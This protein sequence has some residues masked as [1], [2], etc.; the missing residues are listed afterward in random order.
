MGISYDRVPQTSRLFLDYAY[1][2]PR[3]AEFFSAPPAELSG[4]RDL[5]RRLR[6]PASARAGLCD[7]LKR[8]NQTF[9]APAAVFSNLERLQDE[10][11]YAVVTGQQVGLFSGP[12][13][14]IYKALTAVKAAQWLS[15]NGLP[16]VPVFWLATEDH[17]L[18]EVSQ[19]A[20]LDAEYELVPISASPNRPAPHSS[21]GSVTVPESIAETFLALEAAL[22]DGAGRETVLRDL[23]ESYRP[24]V[25]LS[26]AFARLMARLFGRWGVIL[27]DSLD[28]D[29]R[30]LSAPV[31]CKALDE[32]GTLRA[33]LLERSAALEAAGYHAQVRVADDSTLLFQVKDG[34]RRALRE[35]D[36]K[37]QSEEN[38][39]LTARELRTEFEQDPLSLSG[40]VLM[41]PIIQDT[42]LPT[43]AYVAGPSELAYLGQAQAIYASFGRPMPVVIPRA[44]FTLV[45]ARIQRVLDKYQLTLE[46]VWQ[47]EGA[48]TLKIAA[49]GLAT[50][51][52]ARFDAAEQEI[53]RL[54]SALA[55]DIETLDPTLLDPLKS[56]TEK[57]K[58]QLEKLRVKLSRAALQRSDVLSRHQR[59]LLQFLYP[60][61][62]LQERQVSGIYFLSRAG[63][64]LLELLLNE[65]Q[66]A[67]PQHQ[68][69]QY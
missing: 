30:H 21:V 13:F 63:Y 67:T 37:F 17:D 22:P 28:R 29:L 64:G 56:T 27:V 24:G 60:G 5:A 49:A 32:V 48:L 42:L 15:A 51:W 43:L 6:Y 50:G 38:H 25:P 20:V 31:Y 40:N 35:R 4:Y 47:G 41:R 33:G 9:A 69:L 61:R 66:L 1:H 57:M 52:D 8:Q 54:L 2:F 44:A 68:V 3:V 12:A 7:A 14:T 46:D 23:K 65:I 11:T 26:L 59:A 58:Q 55:R 45:D 18:E 34:S 36:G 53:T 10:N 19:T 62:H 39:T 16:A